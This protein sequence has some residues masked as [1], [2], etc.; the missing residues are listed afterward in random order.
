MSLVDD[1]GRV[2]GRYNLVDV[3]V[4]VVLVGL[5]PLAYGAYALFRTPLPR[6]TIVEP[7]TRQF[8]NEFRIVVKGEHLR[9]YMRVSLDDMQGRSF[10][11]KSATSAEVVFGDV[12]PGTYDVVLYDN[13]QE[14]SRLPQSFTLT[15]AALPP[16]QLDV[17]GFLSSLTPAQV[18]RIKVGTRFSVMAEVLA[19]GKPAP[20]RAQV[21]AGDKPVE[22][23]IPSTQRLPALLRV[24]CDV[25]SGP[26]GFGGCVAGKF[27]GPNVYL[28]LPIETGHVP[29]LIT[30][31]RAPEKATDVEIKI[32]LT[33]DPAFP[34]IKA[35]DIDVGYSQNEFSGGARVVSPPA[36]S[37]GEMTLQVPAYPSSTG[38]TYAGQPLRVGAELLFVSARYQFKGLITSVPPLP[39]F[40]R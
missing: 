38:W 35:G 36:S 15:P 4:A 19:I 7:A 26:G 6:L 22:I 40:S 20:D 11:F 25:V 29:F 9:P 34:F 14:R 16:A 28:E 21:V 13:A 10:L 31:V 33:A 32:K 23:A 1:R 2:F 12:P 17:A 37:S 8:A 27:L 5:I 39:V 18:E 30:E 3:A 24:N